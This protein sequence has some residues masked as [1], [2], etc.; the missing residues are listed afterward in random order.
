MTSNTHEYNCITMIIEGVPHYLANKQQQCVV[1]VNTGGY[2]NL[3][4]IGSITF[5]KLIFFLN[6]YEKTLSGNP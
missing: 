1:F 3:L 4:L 2:N 6:L 5:K